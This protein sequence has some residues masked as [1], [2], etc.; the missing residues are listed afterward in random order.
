[1]C[2]IHWIVYPP[3]P[4]FLCWNLNPN[5]MVFGGRAFVRWLGHKGRASWLGLMPLWKRP[6]RAPCHFC[7]VGDTVGR[8]LSMSQEASPHQILILLLPWSW[9]FQASRTVYKPSSLWCFV[10]AAWTKIVRTFKIEENWSIDGI[11]HIGQKLKLR[12]GYTE[13]GFAS[14]GSSGTS[15]E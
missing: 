9:T 12:L 14:L 8:G 6:Q 7:C 4:E 5:M 15:R 13:W 2:A 3:P 11:P 10:P 1:M